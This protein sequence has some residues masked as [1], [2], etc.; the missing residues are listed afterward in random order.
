MLMI[1]QL[2]KFTQVKGWIVTYNPKASVCSLF[3]LTTF[4]RPPA[5][6][7]Q[8]GLGLNFIYIPSHCLHYFVPSFFWLILCLK[9]SQVFCVQ[10]HWLYFH[11]CVILLIIPK[12]TSPSQYLQILEYLQFGAIMSIAN[13]NIIYV[14]FSINSSALIYTQELHYYVRDSAYIQ[15][16][17]V[18]SVFQNGYWQLC[19]GDSKSLVERK[20][21]TTFSLFFQTF[22]LTGP[23]GIYN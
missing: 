21:H 18:L 11:F 14:L 5:T 9:D 7:S 10:K 6:E 20:E 13:M 1:P 17:I 8:V 15:C 12:F 23:L 16:H 3:L 2:K 22:P 4:L 19:T